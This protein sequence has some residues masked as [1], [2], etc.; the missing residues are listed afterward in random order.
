MR[1]RN[2]VKNSTYSIVSYFFIVLTGLISR[3]LFL[4]YFSIEFLG[5]EGLFSNIFSILSLAE[6]GAGAVITYNLY[7][8]MA[9]GNKEEIAKLMTMYKFIYRIIGIAIF[10]IGLILFFFLGAIITQ[11]GVQWRYIQI[12]YLIQLFATISSFFFAYRRVLYKTDQ[13]EY[14]FIKIDTIAS[15]AV[16]L[17]RIIVIIY[18]RNYILYLITPFISN[19]LSNIYISKQSY[20]DY[21]Y[22][23]GVTLSAEDYRRRNFF[24]DIRYFMVHRVSNIIYSGMS[25]IIISIF[26]G[27][28]M[29]GLYSNYI[30][31]KSHVRVL[32][33]RFFQ[34]LQASIGN[35]VYSDEPEEKKI[36][37]FNALDLLGFLTASFV[38]VSFFVLFQPFIRIWLN[39]SYLLSAL[40]VA[41]LSANAYIEWN[42]III[43][44]YRDAFGQ[45][46]VD[47]WYMAA[48]ALVS[49]IVSIS[50]APVLGLSGIM[51]GTVCGHFFIWAG[52]IRFVHLY[53]LKKSRSKY[54]IQ[55]LNRVLIV[56]FE[57]ALTFY[58]TS[59]FNPSFYGFLGR[60]L[61]CL[62]MPNLI[63]YSIFRKNKDFKQLVIYTSK[64]FSIVEEALMSFKKN[65]R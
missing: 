35:L 6:L 3:R 29:V 43:G 62:I 33:D 45:Y 7:N 47:K 23:T 25:N 22:T 48:S 10:T 55:Q 2:V 36:S 17:I 53:Y 37:I 16:N 46:E 49:V 40:F 58:V 39:E 42:S 12:I 15:I 44:Y 5:Y 34:P 64:S 50:L 30:L 61:I 19:L 59:F 28:G 4:A 24:K 26:L 31:I 38:S 27:I 32:S 54:L 57:V 56:L 41:M 8:E 63:N 18:F 51:I 13:K 65:K 52:R 9:K 14:V 20:L 1:T 11:H 60:G 21:P